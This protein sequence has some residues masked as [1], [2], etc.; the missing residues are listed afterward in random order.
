MSESQDLHMIPVG[1]CPKEPSQRSVG[2]E[3]SGEF[4]VWGEQTPAA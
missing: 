2:R 3:S 1:G 4:P